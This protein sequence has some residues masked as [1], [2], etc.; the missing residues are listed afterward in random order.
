MDT[1]RP[2]RPE[3]APAIKAAAIFLACLAVSIGA[4]F[5]VPVG[6][7][8]GFPVLTTSD[9]VTSGLFFFGAVICLFWKPRLGYCLGLVGGSIVAVSLV[10]S[11][12]ELSPATT[13]MYLTAGLNGG[14]APPFLILRVLAVA[15]A[16]TAL[17]CSAIR[18]LPGRFCVRGRVLCRLTWPALAI[19]ST[20]SVLWAAHDATPYLIPVCRM[21]MSAEVTVLRVRKTGLRI[22]QTAVS[23]SRDAK[24]YHSL[25]EHR[26]FHPR[27][28]MQTAV[29]VIP[30]EQWAA[31]LQPTIT[32]A[33][34]SAP[35]RSV[36][37]SWNTERW[38]VRLNHS[39]LFVF[40]APPPPELTEFIRRVER[41]PTFDPWSG[42]GRDICLGFR[43]DP[44]AE[45]GALTSAEKESL[46]NS[47]QRP[48]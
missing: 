21:G 11:E 6:D 34:H 3:L 27:V 32:W 41:Q 10:R 46:L 2:T 38:Y 22:Q 23:V 43:Y 33:P 39:R 20:I 17:C 28:Q 37:W 18:L 16:T 1:T 47:Q 14:E 29:G 5:K 31:L 36:L 13:W 8:F 15:F 40:A 45:L 35:A 9:A 12:L 4:T 25:Y 44:L 7:M 26:L 30:H 19:G 42:N 48:D 24:F